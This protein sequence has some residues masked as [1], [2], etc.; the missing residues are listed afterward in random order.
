MK[1]SVVTVCYNA[2]GTIGDT[3]RSVARQIGVEIEH[4]V[5]DGGSSDGTLEVVRSFPH[6]AKLVSE[7]DDGIYDAMNKGIAH[8][9]GDAIGFLNADDFFA[10]DD[11]VQLIVAG[12]RDADAVMGDLVIVD[13]ADD[14]RIRR[15]YSSKWFKPWMLRVGHMP[16][17]PT[18]YV[19]RSV[20]EEIGGFDVGYRIAGD[21]DFAVRL[22]LKRSRTIV[23]RIPATL[24]TFRHGGAST[25]DMA[26]KVRMNR[27]IH[28]S[29]KA[30]GVSLGALALYVRYPFKAWQL[31]ARPAVT[32][33]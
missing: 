28:R 25:R 21:F 30:R 10:R 14:S 23:K 27:E 20:F 16:P 22:L 9:T 17:H 12:L 7:R 6:V 3:L 18:L 33:V 31:V 15:F 13:A 19:R 5:I 26:A 1:I 11:A 4:I 29:L 8:A 2:A 24:V 32:R